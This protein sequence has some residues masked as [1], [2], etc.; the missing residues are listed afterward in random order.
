MSRNRK[1][2]TAIYCNFY[3]LCIYECST[4]VSVLFY[5]YNRKTVALKR[6]RK[7]KEK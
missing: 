7:K 2:L 6:K 4:M 1:T 3:T 5:V